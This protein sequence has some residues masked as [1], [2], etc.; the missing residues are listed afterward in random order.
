MVSGTSVTDM[1]GLTIRR[2]FDIYTA[3]G[4][5]LEERNRYREE[6]RQ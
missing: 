5:I 4:D 3:V 6:Q 2:F 1:L